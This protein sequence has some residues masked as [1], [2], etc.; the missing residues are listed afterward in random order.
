MI[1][2]DI[3]PLMIAKNYPVSVGLWG[4][5]SEVIPALIK[6]VKT[7]KNN[8]Y[9]AEIIKLKKEW[10]DLLEKEADS[11]NKPIRPQYIIKVLNE[12]ISDDAI[13]SLD[14]GEN[15]WWFGRNF[16][17]KKTQKM[18]MS[19]Y[20]ASM[21]AGLPGALAAKLIYPGKQV[22]CIVGD[23]GFSMVMGDFLTAVKYEL[24]V[25][26]FLFNNKQLGMIMQEQKV[27]RYPNWQT[28]LHNCDF[29][30]YAENCGGVGI[31][32]MNPEDLTAAIEKALS[33]NKP[34]IIDINTD[35]RRFI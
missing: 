13:I 25:K 14:V 8:G 1:Q 10:L 22:V 15:S 12:K 20:L 34:V 24:P 29:A 33:I 3:D 4:N 21:G 6:E 26:V 19:G 27:E 30:E 16:W 31:K 2:I 7:K 28:D 17:M 5:C 35:P 11:T 18:V 9:L 23:G 32:V